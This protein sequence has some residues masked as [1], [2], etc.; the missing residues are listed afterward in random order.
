M[1]TAKEALLKTQITKDDFEEKAKNF[2]VAKE[3]EFERLIIEAAEEGKTKIDIWFM[4]PELEI[5]GIKGREAT[6]VLTEYLKEELSDHGY[7][8]QVSYNPFSCSL[9]IVCQWGEE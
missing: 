9:L 1:L 7:K 8:T 2:F 3:E 4:P 6:N 5:Y